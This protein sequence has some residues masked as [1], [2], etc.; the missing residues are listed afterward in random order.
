[1]AETK[2]GSEPQ[3]FLGPLR[4]F[5]RTYWLLNTIEMFERLAYFSLRTV[6]PIYIMQANDPGGLHL[7]AEKKGLIYGFWFI[8]QSVLPVFTGGIADRYGYKK[9]LY[10]AI[11]ANV[12]GY[13]I[14]AYGRSYSLFFTGVIVL[15]T[16]TAFFKPSLWGSLAQNLNK[17]NSSVGWGIFYW[18]VNIGA[19]AGPFIARGILGT[20]HT[21]TDWRNLYLLCAG[22]TCLN[23]LLLFTFK[24]VPSGA[25]K[26]EGI[27]QVLWRTLKNVFEP[28]LLAFL[29]ILSCFW[30][31][32]Y[33]LWD[34]HP[35]FI[36][37]WIDSSNMAETLRK[38][39]HPDYWAGMTERGYQVP[40]ELL[41][42]LNA[43]LIILLVVPVSWIVR[44]MRTLSAMLIGMAVATAGIIVSGF[45]TSG[46][47]FVW[48]VL[49]F[50]LG[51]MLTGPK[52]TEYLGLI[53]PPGKKGL[54]LGYVNIPVGVGGFVGSLLAGHIYGRW[55]E[56]ATLALKYIAEHTEYGASR[57]WDGSVKTLES[58]MGIPRTEAMARLQELT[59][60][61]AVQAT[62]LLWDTYHPQYAVWIPIAAI[63]FA[64][65]IALAVFG[66]MA[67]RWKD[68]NA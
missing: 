13:V 33:Q 52:K 29:A 6:A 61:D 37:D 22:F 62:R 65:I 60:M 26:T 5:A 27:G 56:K 43:I 14:M 21:A 2:S 41:L 42:S 66:Q 38:L 34:L 15:A 55:G 11:S 30:L 8:F 68:M 53:A 40:Q 12:L 51:E 63:G 28:R 47:I 46:W 39:P 4:S 57:A 58:A 59:N 54:Y 45:T 49:F 24:D 50:S 32:M 19:A 35:N 67:K 10:F 3:G 1:M 20:S 17:E 16:G 64:A 36:T 18:V 44:K 23:I 9:I 7:T 25:D 48:G 31:M